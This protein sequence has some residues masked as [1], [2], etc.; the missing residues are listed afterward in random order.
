MEGSWGTTLVENSPGGGN[1]LKN[2]HVSKELLNANDDLILTLYITKC[3]S[4]H[5]LRGVFLKR[6]Q[7]VVM[8]TD[9]LYSFETYMPH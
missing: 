1:L 2:R 7:T 9:S 3:R 5:R 8:F 4:Q 6:V